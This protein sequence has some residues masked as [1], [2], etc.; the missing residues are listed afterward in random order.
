MMLEAKNLELAGCYYQEPMS[1]PALLSWCEAQAAELWPYIVDTGA[2]LEEALKEG[3]R[4]VL[5][6]QLGAM[7]DIDYGIFHIRQV[8]Q[9]F[10]PTVQ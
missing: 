7:R 6:A 8:L 3:K 1:Y 2:Y 10:L 4:V 9:R 5:E